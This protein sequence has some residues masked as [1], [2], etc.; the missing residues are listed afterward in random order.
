MED[1]DIEG[2]NLLARHFEAQHRDKKDPAILASAWDATLAALAPEAVDE[3]DNKSI[4]AECLR[5]AVNL[6]GRVRDEGEK[7]GCR[8]PSPR[9]RAAA[10]R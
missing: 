4:K 9:G 2:L 8:A 3:K 5:R 10:W 1:G 7:R 6:A